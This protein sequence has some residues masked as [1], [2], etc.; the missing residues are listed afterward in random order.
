MRTSFAIVSLIET[1]LYL[2]SQMSVK[3]RL[4]LLPHRL[5][6]MDMTS[7]ASKCNSCNQVWLC[8]CPTVEMLPGTGKALGGV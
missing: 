8:Q 7:L 1:S 6:I 5:L 3:S 2:Y 4:E